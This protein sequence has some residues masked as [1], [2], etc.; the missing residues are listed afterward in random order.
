MDDVIAPIDAEGL[1]RN[2]ASGLVGGKAVA[3]PRHGDRARSFEMLDQRIPR[4]PAPLL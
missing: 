1:A 4:A 2:E 3:N